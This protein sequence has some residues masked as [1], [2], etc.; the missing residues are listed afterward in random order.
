MKYGLIA[1]LVLGGANW[2]SAENTAIKEFARQ[3]D[4]KDPSLSPNGR[5]LAVISSAEGKQRIAMVRDL[6]AGGNF[7]PVLSLEAGGVFDLS[8]CRWANDT[9]LLCALRGIGERNDFLYGTLKLVA[10]DADGKNLKELNKSLTERAR[11]ILDWTPEDPDTVMIAATQ[12]EMFPALAALEY[13]PA[14]FKLNVNTGAVDTVSKAR[15]EISEYISDGHGNVRFGSGSEERKRIYYGR[16][17]GDAEWHRLAKLGARERED[18]LTLVSVTTGTNRAYAIGPGNGR[19]ALWEVDLSDQ[20]PPKVVFEHPRSD[21]REALLSNDAQLLG[22]IYDTDKPNVHYFDPRMAASMKSFDKALPNT[23]NLIRT[24]SADSKKLVVTARNDIDAGSYYLFDAADPRLAPI[25]TAYPEFLKH[26]AGRMSPVE[27]KAQDGTAI[28]GYLLAPTGIKA[29]RLPLVVVANSG[30]A[31][32]YWQ[33]DYLGQ[34]LASRGYAVLFAD[35]RGTPGYGAEWRKAAK[36]NPGGLPYADLLDGARW[37]IAQ[38]IGD[39]KRTCILGRGASGGYVA[40]LAATRNA[41]LFKCAISIGGFSDLSDL[42]RSGR[43]GSDGDDEVDVGELKDDAPSRHADAAKIPL[44]LI[45]GTRD[46]AVQFKQSDTMAAALKK[47]GK[48]HKF[49][50]IDDADFAFWRAA[51]RATLLQEV[52]QFLAANTGGGS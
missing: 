36:N 3:E 22:V 41:D 9:R 31:R 24:I 23:F 49:V 34:F 52:E 48:P 47:A 20:Q 8:W 44:L 35:P 5:Y 38:G 40:Q 27:F 42:Y 50:K 37:A 28:P 10:V 46:S 2:A 16:A 51:E 15:P 17:Q 13:T 7:A 19:Y 14:I 21:V 12:R 25:G 33:F 1:L 18:R 39:A 26:P 11:P 32:Q 45:H 30:F 29:E 43:P 6:Q 4:F